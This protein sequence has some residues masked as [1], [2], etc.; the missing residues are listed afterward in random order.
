MHNLARTLHRNDD[1]AAS[2]DLLERIL[3]IRRRLYGPDHAKVLQTELD[4]AVALDSLGN[5][6]ARSRC[7]SACLGPRTSRDTDC[8]AVGRQFNGGHG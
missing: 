7:V 2:R 4:L 6:P 3:K 8:H 1:V 5:E